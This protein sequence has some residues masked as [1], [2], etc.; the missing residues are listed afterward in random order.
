MKNSIF[1]SN[2]ELENAILNSLKLLGGM[3]TTSQIN[4]NVIKIL[5]L[6]DDVILMEDENGIDTKL[7][8]R[9]RWCRTNLKQRGE[10]KNIKRGVWSLEK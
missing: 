8:Y 7:N 6:S 5:N 3:G 2:R 1:P 9:L 4:E 10:I